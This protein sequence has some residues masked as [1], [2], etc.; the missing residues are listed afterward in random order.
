MRMQDRRIGIPALEWH[1]TMS[2]SSRICKFYGNA[3]IFSLFM[4]SLL[5]ADDQKW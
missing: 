3:S 2:Q 5:E 4:F 1:F